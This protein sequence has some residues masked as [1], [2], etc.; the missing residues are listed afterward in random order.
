MTERDLIVM[1]NGAIDFPHFNPQF[2]N[3]DYCFSYLNKQFE[4]TALDE[5]YN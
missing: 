3:K 4:P 5:N 2:T 1:D